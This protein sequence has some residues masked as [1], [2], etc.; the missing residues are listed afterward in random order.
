MYRW[1]SREFTTVECYINESRDIFLITKIGHDEA[2]TINRE[3]IA[4][5]L[6]MNIFIIF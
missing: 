5:H 3:I 4:D 2:V 6:N 1:L